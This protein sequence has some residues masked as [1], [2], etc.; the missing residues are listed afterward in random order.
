MHSEANDGFE[1]APDGLLG[2]VLVF[3]LC[4][5]QLFTQGALGYI[6]IPLSY[7]GET[8]HQ[9][10]LQQA[11]QVNWHVAAYSLTIGSFILVTGRLGDMHGSKNMVVFGWVWFAVWS[12]V[13]GC[14]ALSA[15][16]IFFDT[17]RA[18]QGVGPALLLPNSLAVAGRTY[19][20]GNKKNIV[21][22]MI[23]MCAP[24]GCVIA[25]LIGS[26][27]AQYWWW[28][29]SAWLSGIGCFILAFIA[30]LVIPQDRSQNSAGEVLRFDWMGSVFGVGGLVLLNVSWNQAP[31]DGWSAPHVYVILILGFLFLA[32]FAWHEKR[33]KQPLLDVSIFNGHVAGILL[34]TALGWSS[35][36]IWFYYLFQF[37]Q[38]LRHVS[39]FDSAL[40][41]LPGALSGMIAPIFTAWAL[42]RIPSSALMILS[43][44]GF[45]LGCLLQAL[46]PVEQSYWFNTFWSF[47]VTPW[48]W[49]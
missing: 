43:S 29:W 25:G 30:Y 9:D 34:T 12:I 49:V 32:A 3:V 47:V 19:P 41:F 13:C 26:A 17:S 10:S 24:L 44:L 40:Q 6:L 22:S 46:A 37:L 38:H 39:S 8:F 18:L 33:A 35:F 31:V 28:P 42:P 16:A 2:C 36:G 20:P 45:F 7:V 5:A 23:A 48:G 1:K 27:F 21:F 4:S 14:S 11:A 15:S